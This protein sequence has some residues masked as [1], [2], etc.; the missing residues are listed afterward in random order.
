MKQFIRNFKK[1][2]VVGLF[3]IGSLSLGI[4][5]AVI[6]GLWTIRELSFDNFHRK[7]EEI[8]RIIGHMEL[9]GAPILHGSTFY[10]FG[11]EA[12]DELPAIEECSRVWPYVED[13][14][15]ENTLHQGVNVMMADTNFFSFFTFRL[16]EGDPAT[17]LAAPKNVVLSASAAIRLFAN[18]NPMGQSVTIDYITFTV[19]GVMDD[20]PDNS[21]LQADVIHPPFDDFGNRVW[22]GNDVYITFFRIPD[23]GQTGVVEEGLKRI[24]YRN[25][26]FFERINASFTLEPLSDMHFSGTWWN[27]DQSIRSGNRDL[28][29]VFM[30]VAL[31]ILVI[32][33]IN[34]INLFISTSFLRARG[35]GIKKAHGAG[36]RSLVV[37]FYIET[38]WYVLIAIGIGILLAHLVLPVFN[39]FT[40][41]GLRI[42][43]WAPELYIFLCIL[44][45]F[46]VLLAGSFPAFYMT[47]F[48]PIQT[49]GGKFRGKNVSVFQKTLVIVQFTASIAL[50][51]VVFFM[52]KQVRFMLQYDLGFNKENV[53]YVEGRGH[54]S[55]NYDALREELLKNP[56]IT[57]ITMKSW[58]PTRWNQGW[59]FSNV[60]S[61]EVILMEMNYIK[62]NYFDFME[63]KIIAGENPFLLEASPGDS[64]LPIVINES[65]QKQLGLEDPVDKI[66][67]ANSNRRMIIKG[68][69]KNAHIR[70]LRDEIDPQVYLK[71]RYNRWNTVF[72]RI[73]GDVEQAMTDV[74]TRWD[75]TET[76]YPFEYRFLDDVYSKLYDSERNAERILTFAMLITFIISVAGLFAMA[77][78]ATQRRI[79]EIGLR[80]VNGATLRDLLLLLNKD[81]VKW[82]ALSFLLAAPVAYFGLRSWLDGF[83]VKTALSIGVFLLVGLL[84]L[85]VALLTTSFQTWKV[86]TMN[87]VETL[88]TE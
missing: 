61:D 76:D 41:A 56:D 10:P 65:A 66:I 23:A 35:I 77:F 52:Q 11:D 17:A 80:K 83:S 59:G 36:K 73:N 13:V 75:E 29:R 28:L 15:A 27:A 8:Y 71:V 21:S 16:K 37:D 72:F 43:W 6:V 45:I 22:G 2:Q 54:F 12:K 53:V 87:P 64:I 18:K 67:I 20:M 34:F 81:F 5:V 69:M 47:G 62:P 19:S 38:V 74:R 68:V 14:R 4:M 40:G 58:L 7:G 55:E 84:T 85:A 48:N 3:T 25:M 57:D 79:K 50:L 60:G 1:Q 39:E 70:S 42:N 88:K 51:I 26:E 32:S 33:C 24:A 9:N 49:L 31:A 86:A 82:V 46:T 78:Y 44:L 63:M 30:L